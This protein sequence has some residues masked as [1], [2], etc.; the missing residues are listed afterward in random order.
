MRV[1]IRQHAGHLA[2]AEGEVLFGQPDEVLEHDADLWV[3]ALDLG[4]NLLQELIVKSLLPGGPAGGGFGNVGVD[5]V[6]DPKAEGGDGMDRLPDLQ[7]R[8]PMVLLADMFVE[9]LAAD[10][11]LDQLRAVIDLVG[12]PVGGLVDVDRADDAQVRGQ[13]NDQIGRELNLAGTAPLPPL[14][15]GTW[16]S[17]APPARGSSRRAL[18]DRGGV[19]LQPPTPP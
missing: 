4:Q 19:P 8:R 15:R 3:R 1:E 18:G 12:E 7:D 16:R 9:R 17:S 5:L 10:L 2:V 11:Q 13:I 14:R 6:E